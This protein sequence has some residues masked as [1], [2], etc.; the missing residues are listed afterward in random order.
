MGSPAMDGDR[1]TSDLASLK[2]NRDEGP[3]RGGILK[4]LLIVAA[5]A[6]VVAAIWLVGYPYLSSR[7]FK[8]EVDI[9]EI[10]LVSPAQGSI[11]LTA[12]GYVVALTKANVAAKTVG[13]VA[14][15]LVKE[16]DVLKKG[17][18]IAVLDDTSAKSSVASA[19]ARVA[20]ARARAQT[21]RAQVAEV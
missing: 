12:T 4:P 2:I 18:V 11:E 20:T 19:K 21:A 3:R 1:L 16:G 14:Q 15:L 17:D 13:R 5:I 9:T 8:T 7:V 6:G 10:A